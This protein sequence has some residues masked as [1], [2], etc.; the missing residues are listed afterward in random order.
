MAS[1]KS[2]QEKLNRLEEIVE[3]LDKGEI[4]LEKSLVL[5]DEAKVLIKELKNTISEAK[6]KVNSED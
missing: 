1:K 5:Y 3:I 4:D 2:F 6:N